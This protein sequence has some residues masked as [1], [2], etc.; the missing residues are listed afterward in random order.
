MKKVLLA[1]TAL[2]FAASYAAADGHAGVTVSGSANA[3]LKFSDQDGTAGNPEG[4]ELFYELDF[5]IAGSTTTDGGIEVG[6]SLDFDLDVGNQSDFIDDPEVFISAGGVTVT[7]GNVG[8]ADGVVIGGLQDPGFDGIGI[9]DTA[10]VF[11]DDGTANVLVEGEFGAVTVAASGNLAENE[12]EA[13][14][15]YAVGASYDAGAFSVGAAFYELNEEEVFAIGATVSAG[16]AD[17]DLFF[18]QNQDAVDPGDGDE[19]IAGYGASVTYPLGNISLVGTVGATDVEED[20]VDFGVGFEYDL[21]GGVALAGGVGSID[22]PFADDDSFAV[23]DFGI[24]MD[25]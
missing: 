11:W 7:V 17:I 6:A 24:T 10:T 16:G 2:V 25:F 13:D 9:D 4:S 15:D 14:D 22:D 21:G 3:G 1:T 19:G 20:E 5:G 12:T 18:H 8:S 23:A